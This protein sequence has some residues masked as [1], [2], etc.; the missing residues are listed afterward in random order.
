MTASM[1]VAAVVSTLAAA[2]ILTGAGLIMTAAATVYVR[3]L[4]RRICPEDE[5]P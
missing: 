3:W 4:S 5:H 1:A 2:A